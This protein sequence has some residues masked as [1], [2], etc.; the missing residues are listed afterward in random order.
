MPALTIAA[1]R[2]TRPRD[3]GSGMQFFLQRTTRPHCLVQYA[4]IPTYHVTKHFRANGVPKYMYG[5]PEMALLYERL[6]DLQL[7]MWEFL[8]EIDPRERPA[9]Q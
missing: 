1:P 3:P 7:S 4:V 9:G 6:T 2:L 5:L 8:V